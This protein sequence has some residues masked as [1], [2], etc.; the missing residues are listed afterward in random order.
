MLLLGGCHDLQRCRK[1]LR[2]VQDHHHVLAAR[3]DGVVLFV[4]H[5]SRFLQAKGADEDQCE[6]EDDC[7]ADFQSNVKPQLEGMTEDTVPA[8]CK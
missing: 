1:D 3:R 5:G 4:S 8:K 7:S 6:N 2:E